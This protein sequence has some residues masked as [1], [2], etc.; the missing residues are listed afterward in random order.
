MSAVPSSQPSKTAQDREANL[1][2][3][4]PLIENPE[5][6]GFVGHSGDTP[7]IETNESEEQPV[8]DLELLSIDRQFSIQEKRE[9][10]RGRLAMVFTVATFSLFFMGFVI[11]AV[12]EGDKIANLKEVLLTVSGIFSGLLGFVIG[13]YFRKGEE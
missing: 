11:V 7:P 2:A 13:Y 3:A 9:D 8:T 1:V 4:A 5:D 12:S 10:A 6:I